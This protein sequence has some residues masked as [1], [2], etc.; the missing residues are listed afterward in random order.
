MILEDDGESEKSVLNL[1]F[2]GNCAF[3]SCFD[4]NPAKLD[5]LKE[6]SWRDLSAMVRSDEDFLKIKEALMECPELFKLWFDLEEP[7]KCGPPEIH[8]SI[9]KTPCFIRVF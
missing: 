1:Y 5:W 4:H 6:S 9:M 8:L 3:D 7:K 2:R